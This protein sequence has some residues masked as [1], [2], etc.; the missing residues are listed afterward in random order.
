MFEISWASQDISFYKL[1]NKQSG[2]IGIYN[3]CQ[4]MAA[5]LPLDTLLG[6]SKNL[7]RKSS[8][9]RLSEPKINLT[10]S[11]IHSEISPGPGEKTLSS[12][13]V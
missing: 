7:A 11:V 9:F 3:P 5:F 8:P 12:R 6:P 1:V 2:G 13:L 10:C 4:L